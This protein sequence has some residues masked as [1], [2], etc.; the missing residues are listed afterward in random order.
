L[1]PDASYPVFAA[2]DDLV[3]AGPTGKNGMDLMVVLM[4]A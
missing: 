1:L 4:A 3:S 2:L